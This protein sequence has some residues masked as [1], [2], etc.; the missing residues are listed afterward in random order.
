[1]TNSYKES[2]RTSSMCFDGRR[3]AAGNLPRER[4]A[5]PPPQNDQLEVK[6]ASES[7]GCWMPVIDRVGVRDWATYMACIEIANPVV[8]DR[9]DLEEEEFARAQT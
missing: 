1:V 9:E 5:A 3:A 6:G 7:P 4:L 2:K 8:T